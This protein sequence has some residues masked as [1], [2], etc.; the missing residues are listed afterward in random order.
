MNN[1]VLARIGS[2]L[3]ALVIGF[4]GINH[5]L[6]A[7]DMAGMVPSAI[8]GGVIWVY[9]SGACLIAAAF[10]ILIGKFTRLAC[11]LLTVLLLV[12]VVSIHIPNAGSSDPNLQMMGFT[13]V[14]KDTGMAGGALVIAGNSKS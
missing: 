8:P 9:I 1:A 14:L 11:I 10:S 13:N 4:F 12:I 5:F 6:H 3:Y 7:H 2:W